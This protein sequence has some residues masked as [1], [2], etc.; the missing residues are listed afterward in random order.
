ML[1]VCADQARVESE[2][3]AGLLSCPPVAGA[4][5]PLGSSA[6]VMPL[7]L[8]SHHARTTST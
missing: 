2:L 3:A 5:H 6:A 1:I 4:G 8:S 7:R